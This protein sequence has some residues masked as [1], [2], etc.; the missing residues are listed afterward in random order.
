MLDQKIRYKI[1][2]LLQNN[3]DL[4]QRDLAIALGVSLGKVNYCIK[5]LLEKGLLN[6]KRFKNSKNKIAYTYLLTPKGIEEK[7]KLTVQFLKIRLDEYKTIKKE[8]R[9]LRVE[10][11]DLAIK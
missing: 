9:Q 4:S 6:S 1:F 3:P 2:K 11:E 7:A 10:V 5:A 8:I